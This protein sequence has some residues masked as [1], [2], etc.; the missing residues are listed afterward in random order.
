LIKLQ[1]LQSCPAGAPF[2]N[3]G[4][5]EVRAYIGDL[6]NYVVTGN[7]HIQDQEAFEHA[8]TAMQFLYEIAHCTRVTDK[9]RKSVSSFGYIN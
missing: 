4:L 8:L 1:F 7:D 6:Y 3:N 2:S 9:M 5:E